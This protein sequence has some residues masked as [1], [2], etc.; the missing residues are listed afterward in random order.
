M[1]N[2]SLKIKD[3]LHK[4]VSC[5][6]N[7]GTILWGRIV[8][9][10]PHKEETRWLAYFKSFKKVHDSNVICIGMGTLPCLLTLFQLAGNTCS[11]L[12]ALL[13][14]QDTHLQTIQKTLH[15]KAKMRPEGI[16]YQQ[17]L[18]RKSVINIQLIIVAADW[19]QRSVAP[20]IINRL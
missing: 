9:C 13:C 4:L 19:L 5:M 8:I 3:L 6:N 14:Y 11:R 17:R 7:C 1:R 18:T 12:Y 15:P 2:N 16:G 10:F 20:W